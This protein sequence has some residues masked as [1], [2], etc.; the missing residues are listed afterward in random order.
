MSERTSFWGGSIEFKHFGEPQ[1]VEVAEGK[2]Y[3]FG[4]NDHRRVTAVPARVLPQFLDPAGRYY[5]AKVLEFVVLWAYNC[6]QG[7]KGGPCA[8]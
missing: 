7:Q 5:R 4:N 2:V 8:S 3:F 6:D 1:L